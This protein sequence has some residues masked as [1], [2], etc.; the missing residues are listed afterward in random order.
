[1][2][3]QVLNCKELILILTSKQQ[4]NKLSITPKYRDDIGFLKHYSEMEKMKKQQLEDKIR[5]RK[6][7]LK[8]ENIKKKKDFDERG[9]T[10]IKQIWN[11]NDYAWI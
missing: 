10:Q 4:G 8:E 9:V 7:I 5:R 3:L 1:M 2:C 6:E 11:E